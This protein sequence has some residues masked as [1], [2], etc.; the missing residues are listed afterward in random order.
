MPLLTLPAFGI[1][2]ATTIISFLGTW[3]KL[4]PLLSSHIRLPSPSH[5]PT[6]AEALHIPASVT[7]FFSGT[8][9]VAPSPGGVRGNNAMVPGQPMRSRLGI[10]QPVG[11]PTLRP[12][13]D[14]PFP[15]A[16]GA[17]DAE[18]LPDAPIV[19]ARPPPQQPPADRSDVLRNPLRLANP[20]QAD[21]KRPGKAPRQRGQHVLVETPWLV[22][23]SIAFCNHVCVALQLIL[24]IVSLPSLS[25]TSLPPLISLLALRWQLSECANVWTTFRT[26][27]ERL[28]FALRRWTGQWSSKKWTPD[29]APQTCAICFEN[30]YHNPQHAQRSA[31]SVADPDAKHFRAKGVCRLDCGHELHPTCLCSWLAKQAFCPVCFVALSAAP[32]GAP[33]S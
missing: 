20:A 30:V 32:P 28:E 21:P 19:D 13:R 9:V 24:I 33:S 7:D 14:A 31:P 8:V 27:V 29:E 16:A 5:A 25:P 23:M 2:T 3:S 6:V 15:G 12:P 22:E 11:Q 10:L 1:Q 18:D 26:S 17:E 4:D